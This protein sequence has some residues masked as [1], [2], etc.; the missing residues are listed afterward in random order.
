MC[1]EREGRGTKRRKQGDEEGRMA[2]RRRYVA[3]KRQETRESN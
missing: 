3:K 1:R 2:M